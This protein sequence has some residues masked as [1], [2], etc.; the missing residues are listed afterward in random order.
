MAKR[1]AKRT[2]D[3]KVAKKPG[4]GQAGPRSTPPGSTKPRT[5][6][7]DT[8]AKIESLAESVVR[9][10]MSG[11]EP[12]I[13]V[14]TRALSNTKWNKSRG[15]LQMGSAQQERSGLTASSRS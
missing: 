2:L 5:V 3:R 13:G 4:A 14:P 7:Q 9:S 10:S 6:T 15:I 11:R 12:T 1:S 8:A